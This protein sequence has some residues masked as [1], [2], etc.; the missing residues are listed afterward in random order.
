MGNFTDKQEAKRWDLPLD[1]GFKT[2]ISLKDEISFGFEQSEELAM[3]G[4]LAMLVELPRKLIF[5]GPTLVPT[6]DYLGMYL[7]LIVSVGK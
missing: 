7:L 1:L 2:G 5:M 4:A 6:L 3:T